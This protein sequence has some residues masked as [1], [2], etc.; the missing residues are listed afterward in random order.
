MNETWFKINKYLLFSLVRRTIKINER[1]QRP[2][3]TKFQLVVSELR[4]LPN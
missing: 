2:K 4:T 3:L 1:L